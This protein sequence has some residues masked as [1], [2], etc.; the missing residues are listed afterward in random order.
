MIFLKREIMRFSQ[1]RK[2]D[3]EM[4]VENLPLIWRRG[5]P[6]ALRL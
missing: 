3:G 2:R 1:K 5:G 4:A 6:R